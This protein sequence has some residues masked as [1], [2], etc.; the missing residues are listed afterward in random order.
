MLYCCN[1]SFYAIPWQRERKQVGFPPRPSTRCARAVFQP[2]AHGLTQEPGEG[3]INKGR[4]LVTRTKTEGN[5]NLD[6]DGGEQTSQKGGEETREKREREREREY[7]PWVYE[8][9][10]LHID[11]LLQRGP[12]SRKETQT[13]RAKKPPCLVRRLWRNAHCPILKER[14]RRKMINENDK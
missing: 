8:S 11:S 5:L 6:L 14:E 10:V 2:L 1:V 7:S 4:G 12:S 3:R 13:K 9:V